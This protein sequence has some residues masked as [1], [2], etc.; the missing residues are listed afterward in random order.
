MLRELFGF[1]K[2]EINLNEILQNDR[3][4]YSIVI[5]S[6]LCCNPLTYPA[7]VKL[8]DNIK[9]ALTLT[10]NEADVNVVSI[11]EAQAHLKSVNNR[12]KPLVENIQ[13]I[14]Q[15]KGLKAFPALIINGEIAF[16][17]GVPS[18]EMIITKL[19]DY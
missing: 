17:G 19:N 9:K 13:S 2:K 7:E 5:L 8:K 1:T 15:T 12:F 10:N 3:N 16:Y 18:V 6:S 14:F 4:K 11:S